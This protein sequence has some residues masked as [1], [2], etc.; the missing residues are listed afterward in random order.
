[1]KL[2]G[3]NKQLHRYSLGEK[4]TP[5]QMMRAK[6]AE[7]MGGFADG[8]LDCEIPECPLYPVQPYRKKALIGQGPNENT[9][10][11]TL[12]PEARVRMAS[13]LAE[14]RKQAK[15]RGK[16]VTAGQI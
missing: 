9:K 16:N 10:K 12:T 13:N 4:L 7:C 6:C 11:R 1:M 14:A 2:Q 15:K 8:R 5:R 3:P